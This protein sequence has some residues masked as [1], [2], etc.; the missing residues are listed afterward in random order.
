MCIQDNAS[1]PARPGK[2]SAPETEI[3]DTLEQ[4]PMFLTTGTSERKR[5]PRV[6]L[7]EVQWG[8]PRHA[9]SEGLVATVAEQVQRNIVCC[10][11]AFCVGCAWRMVCCCMGINNNGPVAMGSAQNTRALQPYRSRREKV[12]RKKIFQHEEEENETG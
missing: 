3:S 8:L 12:R 6:L 9:K 5:A 11:V 2:V 7:R 10:S 4:F 1:L